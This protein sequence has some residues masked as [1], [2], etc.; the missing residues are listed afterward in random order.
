MSVFQNGTAQNGKRVEPW[1][2][3]GRGRTRGTIV[4]KRRI[5]GVVRTIIRRNV[6]QRPVFVRADE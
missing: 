5:R 4:R 3:R 6:T 1:K 2:R